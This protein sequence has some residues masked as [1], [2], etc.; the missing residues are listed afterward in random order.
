MSSFKRIANLL[1]VLFC[2]YDK[3]AGGHPDLTVVSSLCNNQGFAGSS[4]GSYYRNALEEVFH[5]LITRTPFSG[6]NHFCAFPVEDDN[7]GIL[8]LFYGH[9]VCNG[10]ITSSE[11]ALCLIA[12]STLIGQECPSRFGATFQLKDCR[13]RYEIY[14]FTDQ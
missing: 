10:E 8:D 6:Y 2:L 7:T 14:P 12:A 13:L 1:L 3:V 9:G 11:C 4:D 5:D